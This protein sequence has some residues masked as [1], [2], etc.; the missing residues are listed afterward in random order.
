MRL[1]GVVL[2]VLL[3]SSAVALA[4]PVV[5]NLG[6]SCSGA[7][8]HMITCTL[9]L[10]DGA[11]S[12]SFTFATPT[13]SFTMPD[14]TVYHDVIWT[15]VTTATNT[16]QFEGSFKGGWLHTKQNMRL[17]GKSGVGGGYTWYDQSG[18]TGGGLVIDEG[19]GSISKGPPTV[20][21]Q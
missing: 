17:V 11:G 9:R 12:I 15:M 10:A 14:G 13:P 21:P 3:L 5:T 7:V 18:S 19:G 20:I 16:Y 2:S 1:T 4:A 8:G 6:G